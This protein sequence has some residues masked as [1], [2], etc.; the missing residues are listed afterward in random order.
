MPTQSDRDQLKLLGIMTLA[1][2]GT[3]AIVALATFA[4]MCAIAVSIA[5]DSEDGSGLAAG[6]VFVVG[7]AV[8]AVLVLKSAWMAF[9]GLGLLKH[10][11]RTVSYIGAGLSC[12]AMPLGTALAVFTFIVLERPGVRALYEGRTFTAPMPVRPNATKPPPTTKPMS[13]LRV[14]VA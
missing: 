9:S 1:Y 13:P 14:R 3:I 6:I 12:M 7:I 5:A 10:K 4:Y 11:W 8:S 2:A